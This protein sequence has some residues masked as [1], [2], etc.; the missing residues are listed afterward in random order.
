MRVS[1]CVGWIGQDCVHPHSLTHSLT[2]CLCGAGI[3]SSCPLF[4][5]MDC[6]SL[7]VPTTLVYPVM[8]IDV[9]ESC[10]WAYSDCGNRRFRGTAADLWT[11]NPAHEPHSNAPNSA[12]ALALMP[13]VLCGIYG[14]PRRQA[15]HSKPSSQAAEG[16]ILQFSRVW[17]RLQL[18]PPTQPP[19][20]PARGDKDNDDDDGRRRR[21]RY[22]VQA[23]VYLAWLCT[24]VDDSAVAGAV[25]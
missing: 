10:R 20:H 14:C 17:I 5:F 12:V 1:E 19:T 6:G 15:E 2:H 16:A 25:R 13:T 9:N 11:P 23:D 7:R 4:P 18:P 22:C 21:R 24:V 8:T 3:N